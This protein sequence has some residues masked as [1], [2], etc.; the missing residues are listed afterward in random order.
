[1]M[2][3][4]RKSKCG[5]QHGY[6]DDTFRRLFE[7]EGINWKKPKYLFFILTLTLLSNGIR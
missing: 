2:C 7:G 4:G 5:T 1:M 6:F 3:E